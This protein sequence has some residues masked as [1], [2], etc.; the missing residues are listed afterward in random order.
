MAAAHRIVIVGGGAGGLPLAAVLG[1]KLARRGQAEVTLVD[2]Y[3]TH[4]WKPLLHEVAAGRMDADSHGVDYPAIAH[5]HGFRFRQG[6][7]TGL[8]RAL[9]VN[10]GL[11]AVETAI[12]A[13]RKWAHKVKGV[14]DGQAE[15]EVELVV[16]EH[17]DSARERLAHVGPS[18]S[19]RDADRSVE[20]RERIALR[21]QRHEAAPVVAEDLHRVPAPAAGGDD[22]PGSMREERGEAQRPFIAHRPSRSLFFESLFDE[23]HRDVA[24]DGIDA[25]ALHA[26]QALLDDGLFAAELL[27]ELVAHGAAAGFGEGNELHLFLAQGTG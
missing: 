17:L 13:S 8:D 23:H 15:R 2:P 24:D 18:P 4:V 25:V 12:K 6:A 3:P 5:R 14:P 20:V 1:D 21:T 11:E 16:P 22:E 26:L 27:A 10:T 7:M 19:R 9:P